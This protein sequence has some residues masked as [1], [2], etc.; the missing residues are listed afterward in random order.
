VIG[1]QIGSRVASFFEL[2]VVRCASSSRCILTALSELYYFPCL[3]PGFPAH[4]AFVCGDP[5]CSLCFAGFG[6]CGYH[7][8]FCHCHFGMDF[9]LSRFFVGSAPQISVRRLWYNDF[10]L[11]V[12]GPTRGLCRDQSHVSRGLVWLRSLHNGYYHFVAMSLHFSWHRSLSRPS[13]T[14]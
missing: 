8:C 7:C 1:P 2:V 3:A 10:C 12:S 4:G 9:C 5:G 6:C 14:A 11:L 13:P